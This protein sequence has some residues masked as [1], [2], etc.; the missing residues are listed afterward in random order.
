MVKRKLVFII[1]TIYMFVCTESPVDSTEK[2][3]D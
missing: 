1:D 3:L 2:S